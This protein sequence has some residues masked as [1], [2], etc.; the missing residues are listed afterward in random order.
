MWRNRL[1]CELTDPES[2]YDDP[3]DSDDDAN[4]VGWEAGCEEHNRS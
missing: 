2:G 3:E 1:R 4:F